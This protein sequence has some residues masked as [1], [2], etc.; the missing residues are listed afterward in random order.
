MSGFVAKRIK[1][2]GEQKS[3]V[4]PAIATALRAAGDRQ[5]A[6]WTIDLFHMLAGFCG[7]ADLHH[8]ALTC[9]SLYSVF[10]VL[11]DVVV[12]LHSTSREDVQKG[13]VHVYTFT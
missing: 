7:V 8:L 4:G 9:K 11:W 1:T 6:L 12:A 2:G 10:L 5:G 13:S 3:P